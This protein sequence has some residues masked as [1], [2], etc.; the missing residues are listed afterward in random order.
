A[1]EDPDRCRLPAAVTAAAAAPTDADADATEVQREEQQ[2]QQQQRRGRERVSK[3]CIG[4]VEQ[5]CES[6]D[7]RRDD[8]EHVPLLSSAPAPPLA[9]RE[10]RAQTRC[11]V[12]GRTGPRRDRGAPPWTY[13]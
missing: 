7:D 13:P 8:R 6:E 3:V 10:L 11:A 1:A 4:P 2:A 9:R 12:H 5:Q